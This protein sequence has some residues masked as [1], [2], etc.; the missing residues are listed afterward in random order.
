MRMNVNEPVWVKL[1]DDG[2]RVLEQN[3]KRLC[4]DILGPY[5]PPAVVNGWTRFQLWELMHELGPAMYNG[6]KAPIETEIA[7]SDPN[8]W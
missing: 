8:N 3:F 4:L 5:K 6:C 1:T 7:L 2:R